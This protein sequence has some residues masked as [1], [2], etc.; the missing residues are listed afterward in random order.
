MVFSLPLQLVFPG[1]TL[2]FRR[3]TNQAGFSGAMTFRQRAISPTNEKQQ[4]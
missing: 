4:L 3:D 2:I 1:Q